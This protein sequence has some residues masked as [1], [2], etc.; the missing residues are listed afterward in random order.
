MK[1]DTPISLVSWLYLGV[2]SYFDHFLVCAEAES[3]NA[4]LCNIYYNVI[5]IIHATASQYTLQ[6]WV[7]FSYD[8][9]GLLQGDSG[10]PLVVQAADDKLEIVGKSNE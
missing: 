3:V 2:V 4:E 6:V 1:Y 7:Q 9:F 8:L 5:I 10:G